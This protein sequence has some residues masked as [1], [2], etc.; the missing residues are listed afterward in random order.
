MR[1]GRTPANVPEA[2]VAGDI[3]A[4]LDAAGRHLPEL[5]IDRACLSS[6]LV[7]DRTP[8]L[9]IFNIHYL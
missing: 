4:D 3:A 2:A 7:R 6:A 9:A 8:D 1:H 5:H